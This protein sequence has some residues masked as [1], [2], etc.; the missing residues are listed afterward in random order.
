MWQEDAP[1]LKAIRTRVFVEEQGVPQEMEWD[2]A[3]NTSLHFM[4]SSEQGEPIGTAR[5]MTN[6][7]DWYRR[8]SASLLRMNT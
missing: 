5:I 7:T 2:D 1:A 3:D 6:G 4:A 8:I